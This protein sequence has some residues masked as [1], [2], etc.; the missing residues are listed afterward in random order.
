[1]IHTLALSTLVAVGFAFPALAEDAP[2]F[3]A[4]QTAAFSGELQNAAAAQQ[5]RLQ[6]SREGYT[7]ISPP[8]SADATRRPPTSVGRRFFV[9]DCHPGRSAAESREP[10]L[11]IRCCSAV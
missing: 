8:D 7:S 6:L 10:E 9:P 3:N 1:M 4:A 11:P 5:A 2:A